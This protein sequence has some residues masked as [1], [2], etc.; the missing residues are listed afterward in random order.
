MRVSHLCF[1][2]GYSQNRRPR[3]IIKSLGVTDL[4][5][6]VFHRANS[7]GLPPPPPFFSTAVKVTHL[8]QIEEES[9]IRGLPS[10]VKLAQRYV[11]SPR[12]IPSRNARRRADRAWN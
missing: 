5:R 8:K 12:I 3:R 4:A 11:S 10:L 7:A 2:D 1:V 9:L 6:V